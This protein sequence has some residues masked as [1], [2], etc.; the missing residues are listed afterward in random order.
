[1][2]S[3]GAIKVARAAIEAMREPTKAMLVGARDWSI[4]KNGQGVG[5]DQATEC[6]RAM[7]DVALDPA[8]CVRETGKA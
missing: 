6:W 3:E 5:N 8:D 4:Q 1:M 2:L 7:I